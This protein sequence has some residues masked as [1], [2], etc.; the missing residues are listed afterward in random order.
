M[1]YAYTLKLLNKNKKP[2][3]VNLVGACIIWGYLFAYLLDKRGLN[4]AGV[5][6][7]E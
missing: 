5:F 7:A 3:L 4:P 6:R 2:P 1:S